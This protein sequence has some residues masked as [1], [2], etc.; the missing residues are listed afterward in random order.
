[1][2]DLEMQFETLLKLQACDLKVICPGH[3]PAVHDPVKYIETE[4]TRLEAGYAGMSS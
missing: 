1:M 3:G 4:L 2:R